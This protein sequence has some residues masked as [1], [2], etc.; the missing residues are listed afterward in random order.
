MTVYIDQPIHPWRGKKWC[1]LTADSLDELHEFAAKI[2]LKRSW[3]Q[4]HKLMPHYDVVEA[5]RPI[6]IE[7]GAVSLTTAEAGARVRMAR[8]K[9]AI[10]HGTT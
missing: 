2:G 6:A 1:H 4:Q 9:E 10:A 8:G 5:K 7:L 3:F